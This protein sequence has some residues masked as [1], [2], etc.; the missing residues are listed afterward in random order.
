M[1]DTNGGLNGLAD[2]L[3][4]LITLKLDYARLTA[5]E[6][7]AVLLSAVAFYAV[8]LLLGAIVLIFV[9]IGIGHLLAMTVAPVAAFLYVAAFYVVVLALVIVLRRKLFVDPIARFVSKLF[10]K[11]P[12]DV[13]Q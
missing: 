9:S 11:P 13:E 4:R 10:V 6:K 12:K 2:T 5:A 7:T 1:D 3:R 8:I